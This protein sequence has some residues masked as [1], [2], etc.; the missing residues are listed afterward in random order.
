MK[1]GVHVKTYEVIIP[2]IFFGRELSRFIQAESAGA[3]KYNYWLKYGD[4]YGADMTFGD[5]VT[6]IKCRVAK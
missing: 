3:A 4:A 2:E 6:K 1:R 5:L